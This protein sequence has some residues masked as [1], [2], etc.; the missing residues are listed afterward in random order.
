MKWPLVLL[1][2]TAGVSSI[3]S[4]GLTAVVRDA[5]LMGTRVHLST[6]AADRAKGL[7][8]L[9]S[10]LEIL[11]ETDR[12]LS[13]WRDDSAISSL[14]RQPLGQ[15]WPA[16]ARLCRMFSELYAWQAATAG[17]FDPGVGP[18]TSAWGIHSAGRIPTPAE[19]DASRASAGLRHL[20]FDAERCTLRRETEVTIDVGAFGK[21]EALDRV[22]AAID[23]VPWLI[24][25]GGQVAVNGLPP[26]ADWWTL[27]IAH[28]LLRDQPYLE[29]RLSEGSLSTSG[30]SERDLEVE[31][32]RVAHHI[33]PR[34]GR[35]A[36][37]KGSVTVAH[38]SAL[39]ADALSTALYVMGPEQGLSWAERRSLAVCFL[40]PQDDGAVRIMMTDAFRLLVG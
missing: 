8:T 33:D 25:F 29:V 35:P 27:A 17:A 15:S 11:E 18:L 30:G 21:G 24:D 20:T 4:A 37:F 19:L 10:A 34:T 36:A 12:E 31:G 13:T 23:D 2:A 16:N 28:P 6:R 3:A 5:Y 26:D 9:E 14:N 7:A 39:A 32:V 1:I 38:S 40:V 22:R